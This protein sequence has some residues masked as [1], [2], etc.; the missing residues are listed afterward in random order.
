MIQSIVPAAPSAW[1][2]RYS[3]REVCAALETSASGYY[4]HEHK[5]K[6]PR[7]QEDE[8]IAAVMK[9][10][11]ECGRG[12]YGSPRLVHGLRARGI[13]RVDGL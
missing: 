11:Y 6:R 8:R 5:T 7:Y 2:G 10:V 9:E 4:A 13:G 3:V 1:D 12:A